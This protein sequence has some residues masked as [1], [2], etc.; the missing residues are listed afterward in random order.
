MSTNQR[1]S[2]AKYKVLHSAEAPGRR[3]R[4]LQFPDNTLG[5][6]TV[7]PCDLIRLDVQMEARWL[8][9]LSALTAVAQRNKVTITKA[10]LLSTH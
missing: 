4:L 6:A 1:V 7:W 5:A 10:P 2:A 3:R 9:L 8:E